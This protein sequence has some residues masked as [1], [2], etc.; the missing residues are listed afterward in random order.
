MT[1]LHVKRP[2]HCIRFRDNV[3]PNYVNIASLGSISGAT[4][5]SVSYWVR[6]DI[7]PYGAV[8]SPLNRSHFSYTSNNASVNGF[9]TQTHTATRGGILVGFNSGVYAQ[10]TSTINEDPQ[11]WNNFIFV[12]D[13]TQATNATRILVYE[14]GVQV[15]LGFTGAVPA[16][17]ANP[18]LTNALLGYLYFYGQQTIGCFDELAIFNGTAI[19][20]AQVAQ[21]S[22]RVTTDFFSGYRLNG[23]EAGLTN[24]FHFDE[25]R[26]VAPTDSKGSAVGSFVTTGTSIPV[27]DLGVVPRLALPGEA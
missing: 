10:G 21:L 13:G 18:G 25:G 12:Y 23:T 14:N 1:M 17:L 16:S 4:K 11:V 7:T 15:T 5:F 27:Y 2:G 26:G 3:S 22:A 20:A 6:H 9:Y 24:L 19:T 8:I